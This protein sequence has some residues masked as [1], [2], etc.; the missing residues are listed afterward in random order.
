MVKTGVVTFKVVIEDKLAYFQVLSM[1]FFEASGNIQVPLGRHIMY[2]NSISSMK[3]SRC[4]NM[5]MP[6]K[7]FCA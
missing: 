6:D 4:L 7:R 5:W 2:Q 3:I 1:K